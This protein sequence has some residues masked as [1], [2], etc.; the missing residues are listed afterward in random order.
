VREDVVPLEAI[1]LLGIVV[2][3]LDA[4]VARYSSLF[5]L[6]FHVFT[7]GRD[8][9]LREVAGVGDTAR[10]LAMD[11]S[12]CFELIEMPGQPEGVR[13]IHFRVDDIEAATAHLTAQG[14]RPMPTCGRAPSARSSS[15]RRD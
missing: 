12:G 8:Y 5:G 9:A 3:D 11:T 6:E 4:A 13:N 2:H 15:T 10:A 14:L 7:P 1:E